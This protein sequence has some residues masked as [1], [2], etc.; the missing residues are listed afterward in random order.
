[1]ISGIIEWLGSV[2]HGLIEAGGYLGLFFGMTLESLNIPLPSE[3]LM[4]FAGALVAEGEF[5]FWAV[6]LVGTLGNLFGSIINYYIGMYGGRP[7]IERYG[8]YFLVHHSDLDVADRWFAKYGLAAVFFTRMMPIIRTFISLPA[9][10]SRVPIVPF[11]VATFFGSLLWCTLLTYIGFEF[12]K[13]Y[14][15][16]F[17][18]FMQKFEI[19]IAAAII[20]GV[21]WYVRRHLK[22]V[23]KHRR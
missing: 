20:F 18:P 19:L 12:G 8:K 13:N 15:T 5:A 3:A 23:R 17:K 7:F 21:A 11:A 1:V 22:L 10:I 16:I 14:E 9:G 4:T 6:V 2:A